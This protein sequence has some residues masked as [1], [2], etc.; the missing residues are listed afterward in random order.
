MLTLGPSWPFSLFLIFFAGMILA[1]FMLMLSM[2][3]EAAGNKVYFSYA[4]IA[5][6]LL[7][8]V[9]GILKNP[10]IPQKVIDRILKN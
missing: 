1:Y 7:V 8:L 6:N 2:C 3:G 9:A 5:A 4:G 10:G